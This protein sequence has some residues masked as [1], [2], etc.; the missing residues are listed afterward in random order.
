M[1]NVGSNIFIKTIWCTSHF[2]I[3]DMKYETEYY[4]TE[5]T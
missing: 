1:A 5:Q 2:N 4:F 3:T